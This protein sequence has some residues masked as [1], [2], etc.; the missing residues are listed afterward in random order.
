MKAITEYFKNCPALSGKSLR[1]DYLGPQ[2]GSVAVVPDGGE[3]TVKKYASGD[4]LGQ[5]A[6]KLLVRENFTGAASALIDDILLWVENCGS[7][8]ILSGGREAQYFEVAE[9]PVLVKTE[10]GAGVYE[11][12]IRLIYYKK[13]EIK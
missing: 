6:L 8:P 4:M 13:G 1:K 11:V 12:K 7:L 10:A 3:Q 5:I 2:S 9:G